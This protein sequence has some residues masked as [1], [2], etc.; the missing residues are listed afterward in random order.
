MKLD[1][2]A[3]EW[4][5]GR[6][7]EGERER[8]R[9]E[10]DEDPEKAQ[11]ARDLERVVEV[12]RFL[13]DEPAPPDLM[14]DVQR[15]I[16]RRS[17]GRHYGSTWAQRLP[18]EALVTGLLVLVMVALYVWNQ[19]TREPLAPVSPKV[20]MGGGQGAGLAGSVLS[21][22]GLVVGEELV[23]EGRAVRLTVEVQRDKVEALRAEVGLYPQLV[24]EHEATP[25]A[26]AEP[27]TVL[28]HVRAPRGP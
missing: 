23:D 14:R 8:F 1:E 15:R 5:D 6:L 12:L 25:A 13:P 22:H 4:V 20:F 19:P 18:F 9:R 10:L 28:V 21:Y 7:G 16:R 17:H 11:E 24:L 26:G 2:K 3:S 27:G